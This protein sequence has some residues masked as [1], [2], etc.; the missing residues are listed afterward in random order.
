M[1]RP[2]RRAPRSLD[3][4]RAARVAAAR[5]Q[6]LTLELVLEEGAHHDL[7]LVLALDEHDLEP[8]DP[9]AAWAATEAAWRERVPDA[10][11][12]RRGTRTPATP[13]PSSRD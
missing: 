12:D 6:A 5:R 8:P 2:H 9:D 3:R 11:D 13:T 4:R 1:D 7:V 10:R